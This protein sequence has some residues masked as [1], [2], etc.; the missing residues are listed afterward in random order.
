M[1]F[2]RHPL[3]NRCPAWLFVFAFVFALVSSRHAAASLSP[4]RNPISTIEKTGGTQAGTALYGYNALNQLVSTNG[5]GGSSSYTYDLE[6]N[7]ISKTE[8]DGNGTHQESYAYDNENRLVEW[9]G[10]VEG[11]MQASSMG[12][13]I[14]RGACSGRK[15]GRSR[16]WCSAE[17]PACRSIC[18]AAT[19]EETS[20]CVTAI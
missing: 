6:G 17:G 18:G 1:P 16:R 15:T 4:I 7:R 2:T 10:E 13:I 5:V 3:R 9:I 8:V 19:R 14:P 20:G 12:M 11:Q